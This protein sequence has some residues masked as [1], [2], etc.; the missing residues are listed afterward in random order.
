MNAE[1]LN[2]EPVNGY[3]T[4]KLKNH[5]AGFIQKHYLKSWGK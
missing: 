1:P 3:K 2:P 4:L 5:F